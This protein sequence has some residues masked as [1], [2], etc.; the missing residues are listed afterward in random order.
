MKDKGVTITAE[1]F[2]IYKKNRKTAYERSKITAPRKMLL[3]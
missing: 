2:L 1:K 3:W